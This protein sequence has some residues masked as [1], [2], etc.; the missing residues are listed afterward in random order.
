MEPFFRC[1]IIFDEIKI[2]ILALGIN[3]FIFIRIIYKF[4]F[5][6]MCEFIAHSQEKFVSR[7]LSFNHSS[8]TICSLKSFNNPFLK[9]IPCVTTDPVHIRIKYVFFILCVSAVLSFLSWEGNF[10]RREIVMNA[11]SQ[12][13]AISCESSCCWEFWRGKYNRISTPDYREVRY[14][15]DS[16]RDETNTRLGTS[17]PSFFTISNIFR[18]RRID[19]LQ[20]FF[21]SKLKVL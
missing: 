15:R 4:L 12:R 19:K 16:V 10:P 13:H 9:L 1:K 8:L 7:I 6:I 11:P 14:Q 20:R 18:M 3:I 21:I 2:L 5:L 17:C